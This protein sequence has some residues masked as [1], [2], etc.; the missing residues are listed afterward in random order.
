VSPAAAAATLTGMSE[1]A[2]RVSALQR[3]HHE[4]VVSCTRCPLHETRTQV[5]VG[6][7][8]LDAD[9]MFVGEAPGYHEDVQGI[10][11]VGQSGKLLTTLLEGIGLTRD[12]VFV[13][14]VLKCRP[15]GNRDPAPVEIRSCE[16]HLFRQVALVQ[17]RLVCTLGNFATKLLSGRPDGIS[18]VHGHELP[19]ELGGR[20]VLLYPLFHP[21]AALY[22]RAMLATLEADFAR[23]PALLADGPPASAP[24]APAPRPQTAVPAAASAPAA[25]PPTVAG[26]E[27]L[28]LF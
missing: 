2:D 4:E 13:A 19:I 22:T 12:D 1:P 14:N 26:D 25:A 20:P 24:P 6:S 9:L 18:R 16:P 3:Y 27:Q 5:V 17:P 28:G 10:P 11:F 15:P 7:G 21:A 8:D 23:I